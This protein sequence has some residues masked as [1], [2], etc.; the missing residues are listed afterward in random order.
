MYRSHTQHV[1]Y[2]TT[3]QIL[4]VGTF[5][6]IINSNKNRPAI[7]RVCVGLFRIRQVG[8]YNII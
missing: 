8:I 6:L 3:G 2:K 7:G 5:F 4:H 1:H